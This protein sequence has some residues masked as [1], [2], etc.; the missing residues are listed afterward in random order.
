MRVRVGD[1]RHEIGL[2][3]FPRVS[4]A[5]SCE[6][7]AEAKAGIR[8]GIDPIEERNV[9]RSGLSVIYATAQKD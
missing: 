3:P 6:K 5:K 8:S 4:L 7:A 2:G 9:A 1:K